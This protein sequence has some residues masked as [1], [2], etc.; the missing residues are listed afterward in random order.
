MADTS[1]VNI[2]N[3]PIVT[4]VKIGDYMIIETGEG[5]R[6][7]DFED[8]AITEYNTTFHPE[9][10]SNSASIVTHE[11]NIAALSSALSGSSTPLHIGTADVSVSALGIGTHAPEEEIHI[12]GT[13]AVTAL[14]ESSGT[15]GSSIK[16]KNTLKTWSITQ[17][18][19]LLSNFSVY[20]DGV[21]RLTF[22][23]GGD[24]G[25]GTYWPT[26][27]L[28][29]SG[30][31]AKISSSTTTGSPTL[32]LANGTNEYHLK[33]DGSDSNSLKL[34]DSTNSSSRL[35]I[36]TTGNVGVGGVTPDTTLHVGSVSACLTLDPHSTTPDPDTIESSKEGRVYV[37]GGKL[38]IQYNDAGV[39]RY[40]YL[41]LTGTGV[42]WVHTTTAP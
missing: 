24:I 19:G 39:K 4:E 41:S 8:F 14:L 37:K 38:V 35:T 34:F 25:I 15:N 10:S 27:L 11:S 18:G 5:T 23:V 33:I 26:S 1:K 2:K 13:T 17:T 12:K 32:K 7:I 40:K 21:S 30:G 6:L 28:H 42:T 9:I 36:D 31:D 20:E 16:F 29:V 3:L 22:T